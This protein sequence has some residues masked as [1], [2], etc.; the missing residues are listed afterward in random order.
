MS[1]DRNNFDYTVA[2]APIHVAA[3]PVAIAPAPVAFQPAPIAK[4][5]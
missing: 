3:P 5:K 1:L 2:A 4:G